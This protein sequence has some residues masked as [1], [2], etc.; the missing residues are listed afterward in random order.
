[1]TTLT[2]SILMGTRKGGYVVID[3]PARV[4]TKRNGR[5]L[6]T[7]SRE[8]CDKIFKC[9]TRVLERELSQKGKK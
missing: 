8:G 7:L 9:I 3:L 1:M 5:V 2:G 4:I 6:K